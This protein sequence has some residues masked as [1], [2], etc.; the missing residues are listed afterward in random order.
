VAD[1]T[2]GRPPAEP[3][4]VYLE[5]GARRVF[6]C[7]LDWPGWCRSGRDEGQALVAL[8]AYRP[9]Y[10]AVAAE[11]GLAIPAA[12]GGFEV[13]ARVAGSATTDFGAPD[14]AAPGDDEPLAPE[15]GERLAALIAAAWTVFDR[16]VAGAPEALRKGPRGGGRDRDA[17]VAHVLGAEASY[18]RT[19]GVRH[20]PPDPGDR[21]AVAA[22]R[23]AIL[24]VLRAGGQTALGRGKGWPLR[25]AARRIA[26]HVLDH[27]WEI[28]DRIEPD[29]R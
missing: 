22:L 1:V 27:A 14:K 8:A 24:E 23:Q 2:A 7:A 28:E 12:D 11:V 3:T 6:A 29:G 15:E 25:Y 18:A 20:R 4:A 16:V 19:I 17:V 9:R 26:W 13:R 10:A 21:A 5:E